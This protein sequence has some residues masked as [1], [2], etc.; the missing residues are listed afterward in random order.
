MLRAILLPGGASKDQVAY[1]E[2]LLKQVVEKPE[3]KE[4]LEANA[5]K[6]HWASGPE[7]TAFLQKDEQFHHDL[8][9]T[10]GFLATE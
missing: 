6:E 10:A 4:Y 1:Y 9:K 3:F 8:M 7:L 2:N 5:L